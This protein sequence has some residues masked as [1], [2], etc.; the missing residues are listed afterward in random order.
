[1]SQPSERR[2]RRPTPYHT[3]FLRAF[4]SRVRS[5]WVTGGMIDQLKFYQSITKCGTDPNL[6]KYRLDKSLPRMLLINALIVS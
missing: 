5:D 1:M 3:P 4:V 6:C 2:V